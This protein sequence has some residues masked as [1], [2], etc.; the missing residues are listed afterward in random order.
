VRLSRLAAT[1]G[2]VVLVGCG[3]AADPQMPVT[4]DAHTEDA[5]ADG[6]GTEAVDFGEV[7]DAEDATRTVEIRTDDS[8]AFDPAQVEVDPGE[9][10]SF[11]ITNDGDVTHEFVLGDEATQDEHAAEM[12][13]GEGHSHGGPNVAEVPAGETTEIT[14]RFPETATTVLYGCHEPGHY[15]AGMVGEIRVG[16]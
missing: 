16:A 6:H 5:H 9:V 11:V 2:A 4:E 8:M 3:V 15:E 1:V 10:V 13:A 12:D 7:A 14:W